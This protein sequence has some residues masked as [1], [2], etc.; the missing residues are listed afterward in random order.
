M[1]FIAYN[2]YTGWPIKGGCERNPEKLAGGGGGCSLVGAR[3]PAG[4]R[5]LAL[6][7]AAPGFRPSVTAAAGFRKMDLQ[8]RFVHLDGKV[9]RSPAI[10]FLTCI[11]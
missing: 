7:W 9:A 10:D 1:D 6:Y 11:C 5:A 4:Y 2:S 3:C 8:H